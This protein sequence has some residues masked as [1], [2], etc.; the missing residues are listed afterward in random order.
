MGFGPA[1]PDG[2]FSCRSP[3]LL[4]QSNNSLPAAVQNE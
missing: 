1:K 2:A 4:M 3:G